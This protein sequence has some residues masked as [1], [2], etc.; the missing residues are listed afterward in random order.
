MD[1][2]TETMKLWQIRKTAM[3][4]CRDRMYT[5]SN[6][7][8]EQTLEQF[9]AQFGSR[10]SQRKPARE[11]LSCLVAHQEDPSNLLVIF[12]ADDPKVGVKVIRKYFDRMQNDGITHGII[13]IQQG[14]T[15]S[16]KQA[17]ADMLPTYVL[18]QFL[19]YELLINITKHQLVPQHIALTTD[20]KI[21]LLQRYKL[22]EDQMP[23][24]QQVDPV[25][26]YYGLQHGQVVKIIRHS[27]VAGKCVS[28]RLVM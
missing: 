15:P 6:E 1:D 13:V 5:V 25:A 7:E 24:I 10:P 2:E 9:I 19:E 28:Y 3:Q 22:K 11:Q 8:I 20:E 4:L 17:L 23:R 14:L 26:R 21:E 12:F 27:E 16:A 18:E